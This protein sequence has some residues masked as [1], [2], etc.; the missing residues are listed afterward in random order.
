MF[1]YV[2]FPPFKPI[3]SDHVSKHWVHL[4]SR[5][6]LTVHNA[7][8][9]SQCGS[10]VAGVGSPPSPFCAQSIPPSHRQS[11][12]SVWL[13]TAPLPFLPTSSLHLAVENVL[14]VFESFSGLFILMWVFSGFICGTGEPRVLLLPRLP[15]KEQCWLLNS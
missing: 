12:R 13:R 1:T 8:L 3:I 7:A 5:N 10:L 9:S 2:K 15:W 6:S 11:C 14:S 4:F